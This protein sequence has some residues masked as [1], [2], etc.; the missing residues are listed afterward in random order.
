LKDIEILL[1]K[2]LACLLVLLVMLGLTL[3]YPIILA[4]F[5]PVNLGPV[6]TGYLGL[7][8]LGM[9]FV[10]CGIFFSSLTRSSVVSATA[11][12]GTLLLFWFLTWNEAVADESI[13]DILLHL[14][15]F[16][17]FHNFSRGVVDT[18]DI[19]FFFLFTYFFLFLTLRSLES[20]T[21]RG[22]R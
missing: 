7:S 22:L 15:L 11:S 12:F 9:G 10:S 5:H 14:S 6:L 3:L 21:W 16:D 13:I 2:F 18:K 1:G 8:L 17:H 19:V 4:T 20:R